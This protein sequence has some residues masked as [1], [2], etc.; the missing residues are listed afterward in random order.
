MKLKMLSY[1]FLIDAV[2]LHG[3]ISK[4]DVSSLTS[5]F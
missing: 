3:I 5:P 4:G 2:S 1:T